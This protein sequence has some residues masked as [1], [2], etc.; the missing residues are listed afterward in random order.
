MGADRQRQRSS[1]LDNEEMYVSLTRPIDERHSD[2]TPQTAD[3]S[4]K[5]GL[6]P[7]LNATGTARAPIPEF[8]LA[9]NTR[10]VI[11]TIPIR[12]QVTPSGLVHE[13]LT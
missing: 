3:R 13:A 2:P 10:W 6:A 5:A 8:P 7:V 9:Y 11:L 4:A 12:P 1:D